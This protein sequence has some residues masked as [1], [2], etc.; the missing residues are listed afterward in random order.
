MAHFATKN[1]TYYLMWSVRRSVASGRLSQKQIYL[2]L[3]PLLFG[4][5]QEIALYAS[6]DA[7]IPGDIQ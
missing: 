6:I 4:H 3:W 1:D 5:C 2:E 7:V